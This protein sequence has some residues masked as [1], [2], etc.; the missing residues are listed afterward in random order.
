MFV[1]IFCIAVIS[2]GGL[3][4]LS[5]YN[6]TGQDGNCEFNPS[7][8]V[9]KISGWE[10]V[11][12]DNDEAQMAAYL[13]KKA[14]LSIC[15]DAESWQDYTSGIIRKGDG[16][17]DSL[18]HCVMATGFDIA[19]DGTPYWIVRNS[20]GEDWGMGGYLFVERGQ[21]VCGISD[22]VTSAIV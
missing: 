22:E 11:T 1:F 20:W 8:I 10:Y 21:N 7:N 16:C 19:A 6:Y 2:A 13:Y 15:V 12:Q 3:D 4:S 18:D 9:A 17:G 5:E 14:P